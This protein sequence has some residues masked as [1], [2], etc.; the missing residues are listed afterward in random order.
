MDT[1]DARGATA[2][3]RIK[4]VRGSLRRHGAAALI[5]PSSDPHISEYLPVRWQGRE[6]LSGFT[7]SD[8]TLIVTPDFAGVWVDSRYYVQAEAQLAGT[9]IEMMKL[10][11]VGG[12]GYVDWL[13]SHLAPGSTVMVDGAVLG[14]GLARTL[15][16]SL[17][18]RGIKLRTDV[19]VLDEVWPDR[20]GLPTEPVYA[21]ELAPVARKDKLAVVRAEM[22]KLG[23]THHSI[24][25]VDD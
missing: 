20:P 23:A 22:G 1:L 16:S 24:S 6:W 19:D 2:R 13:C 3:S 14:L 8:G 25:T 9:G 21:H 5:V 12:V 15:E 18:A 7:G 10:A 17:A 11:G 4:Q